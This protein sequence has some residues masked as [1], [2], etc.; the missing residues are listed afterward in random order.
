MKLSF[1][2]LRGLP[3][4]R[5]RP[6]CHVVWSLAA[7]HGDRRG[8]TIIT[9]DA[10][11]LLLSFI[12]YHKMSDSYRSRTVWPWISKFYMDIHADLVDNHTWYYVNRYFQLAVPASNDFGLN[13][14][15]M[16]Q[17]RITEFY[18]IMW[19]NQPHK[20]GRYDANSCFQSAAKCKWILHKCA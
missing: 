6:G 15:R 20:Q 17:A 13:L 9:C 1:H 14:S 4:R 18:S 12:I 2:D 5:L 8:C 3:L 11:R 10:W 19:D 7:Y 16:V